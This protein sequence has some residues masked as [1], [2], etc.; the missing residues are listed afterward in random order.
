MTHIER[1]KRPAQILIDGIDGLRQAGGLVERLAVGVANHE[2]QRSRVVTEIELEGV[3]IGI[4]DGLL[5][6]D[7]GELG[8]EGFS[9]SLDDFSRRPGV[10]AALAK[11]ATGWRAR[12][13]LVWLTE[14]QAQSGIARIRGS[15]HQ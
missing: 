12:H 15:E 7:G 6:S 14:A 2:L 1:G 11:W 4:C 8:A 13:D 3:V 9:R 5:V 10:G